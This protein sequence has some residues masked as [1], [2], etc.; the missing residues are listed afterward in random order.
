M[1]HTLVVFHP[2]PGRTA[3][4]ESAH[5]KLVDLMGRQPGCVELRA[6]RSLNAPLEYMVYGSWEDKGAWDRAHQTPEFRDLFKGLPIAQHG[7][8]RNS[9]FELV[10]RAERLEAT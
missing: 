10:Y 4:F 3:E 9:F 8:S 1:I 5:R 2:Q 7:L 6:H